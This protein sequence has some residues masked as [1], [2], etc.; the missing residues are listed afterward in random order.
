M[1][2]PASFVLTALAASWLAMTALHE[3]GHML[4]AWLSG[5]RVMHVELPPRGL[6]HTQVSPNPAPRFVAWGGAVWGSLLGTVPVLV[7][8]RGELARWFSRLF[9]GFCLIANGVYLG[10]GCFFGDPNGADDAHELL[11]NG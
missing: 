9:A 1:L 6:G 2:R 3:C 5:G 4:N 8:R 10:V 7:V 11:R